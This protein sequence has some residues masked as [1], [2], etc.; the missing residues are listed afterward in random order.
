MNYNAGCWKI[1][2][3]NISGLPAPNYLK[4]G[5]YG[6]FRIKTSYDQY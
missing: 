5:I 2:T 6:P 1:G 4:K 3:P